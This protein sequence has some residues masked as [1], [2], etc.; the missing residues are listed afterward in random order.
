MKKL[1]LSVLF[2]AFALLGLQAESQRLWYDKAANNWLEAL[3]IGNS[4]L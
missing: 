4:H 1:V 3:P 2:S